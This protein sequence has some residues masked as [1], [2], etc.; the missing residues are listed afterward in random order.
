MRKILCERPFD[1]TCA[2]RAVADSPRSGCTTCYCAS[3]A[4]P[5]PVTNCYIEIINCQLRRLGYYYKLAKLQAERCD[6]SVD[7]WMRGGSVRRWSGERS[8]CWGMCLA[9]NSRVLVMRTTS[10]KPFHV[11]PLTDPMTPCE[12]RPQRVAWNAAEACAQ[13]IHLRSTHELEYSL[14]NANGT[15]AN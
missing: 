9:S 5:T 1:C 6:R 10:E 3:A 4:L 13:A 8:G 7:L 12:D 11:K 2:R 14:V 15:L